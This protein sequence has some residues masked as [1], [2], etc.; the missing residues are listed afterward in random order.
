[1]EDRLRI[2]HRLWRALPAGLRR[3][4]LGA[5]ARALSPR[6]TAAP[7]RST[8]ALVAG[9][10]AAP[11]GMGEAARSWG[12]GIAALGIETGLIPLSIG[13]R[14]PALPSPG[15]ALILAVNAP[16]IPLM[17]ARAGRNY[18]AGRRIIGAWAWE[19]PVAPRSWARAS[20]QVHE[21]WAC[22]AFAAAALE[23]LFP[24]RVTAVPFP[25]A[26]LAR[27]APVRNRAAF[28]LPED[29]V[30]TLLVFSL[31][32]SL[33]R[34]NP[35]AAIRA[36]KAAFG[37]DPSQLLVVKFS[38]A[39]AY[40]GHAARIAAEAAPN[41]RIMSGAWPSE[42]VQALLA[43]ADIL[44]SLHRAEGFGLALAEAMLAGIPVIATGWSGNMDFMDAHSAAL[45]G[46]EL[47]PVADEAG[48]YRHLPAARWAAPDEAQAAAHL[49]RLA[50][51]PAAR[52]ALGAKGRAYA[53]RAL[54]GAAL[55]Q[56]L[57]AAG[58]DGA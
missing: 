40:P 13:G 14:A 53:A 44:L 49:Q 37:N 8:G 57:R 10:I 56:A 27:P 33:S 16:S 24:G 31:G 55:A 18:L 23:P 46:C 48:L 21:V 25:L 12:G 9:E 1:L 34:K 47:I 30:V 19:L 20:A 51:D 43:C 39:A 11:T 26:R 22:S 50:S 5:A 41:I 4:A 42:R 35:L 58:I 17:L 28:G 38:G 7:A 15:A 45:V 54:D 2:G 29:A 6:K 52:A 36:F 32:S 3:E